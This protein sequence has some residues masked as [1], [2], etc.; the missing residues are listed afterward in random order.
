VRVLAIRRPANSSPL[1]V[2]KRSVKV[3]VFDS[4]DEQ[5]FIAHFDVTRGGD[6]P[7]RPDRAASLA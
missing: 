5:Y 1:T 7:G 6:L 3:V 2:T 4:A